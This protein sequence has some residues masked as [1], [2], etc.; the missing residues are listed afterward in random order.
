MVLWFTPLIVQFL[1]LS[2]ELL[3][4]IFVK[5]LLEMF[6]PF[7]ATFH[8]IQNKMQIVCLCGWVIM[9]IFYKIY[10]V[11]FLWVRRLNLG[12]DFGVSNCEENMGQMCGK[13]VLIMAKIRRCF[14]QLSKQTDRIFTTETQ[15]A[16]RRPFVRSG[17]TDRAKP[18][19]HLVAIYF[20]FFWTLPYY[21][22]IKYEPRRR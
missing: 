6:Y 21:S 4:K 7:M 18:I 11:C 22:R 9:F 16:Q 14:T 10:C 19:C 15:R 1:M 13:Q 5:S 2:F 12:C 17:D 3:I 8:V 20:L